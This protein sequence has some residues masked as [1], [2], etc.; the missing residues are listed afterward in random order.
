MELSA[1][2][3]R[4][5]LLEQNIILSGV[6]QGLGSHVRDIF[7]EQGMHQTNEF[8]SG[9][10]EGAFVL[11]LGHFL[12]LAPK[13]SFVLEVELAQAISAQDE[14]VTAVGIADFGQAGVL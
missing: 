4:G 13:V 14:V 9:K 5:Y 10:D 3:R 12:V 7:G 11:M 8:T 2:N 6:D 1:S